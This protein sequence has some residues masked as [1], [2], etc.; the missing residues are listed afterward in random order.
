MIRFLFV[1]IILASQVQAGLLYTYNQLTLKDLDQMNALVKNKL[2]ES[3]AAYSGKI[4]PIK[5]GIQAIFSRPN[6]DDM[7]EKISAPLRTVMEQEDET[8]KVFDELVAEALN[9]LT[10]TKNFKKEVQVTYAIFL[11]NVISEF[12]PLIKKDSFEYKLIKKIADRN[13]ELTKDA[14]KDRTLR[15]MQES[16][17]PSE[18]AKKVLTDF[19]EKLKNPPP[20]PSSTE[21][22]P[23][24]T[25]SNASES[26]P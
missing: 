7:I 15:L 11:E 8:E 16:V 1:T 10:N 23:A 6:A 2:Q 26:A 5:E 14:Q 19:E 13:V 24:A 20:P 4:V 12:K 17:S 22:K 18:I 3:K 9:A 25:E 21:E